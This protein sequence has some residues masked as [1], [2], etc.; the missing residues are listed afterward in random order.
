M[1]GGI[2]DSR[3]RDQIEGTVSRALARGSAFGSRLYNNAWSTVHAFLFSRHGSV[4]RVAGPHDETTLPARGVSGGGRHSLVVMVGESITSHE[5]PPSGSIEIGRAADAPL[6]IDAPSMS[7]RHLRLWIGTTVELEDLGGSNGT[8][9]RGVRLPAGKRV[10]ISCDEVF[11]AGD[12]GLVVQERGRSFTAGARA[13]SEKP[14]GAVTPSERDVVLLD[15]AMVR[16][17]A[18]AERVARGRIPVLIV[19]ETGSGKEVLAELVHRRSQRA[20]GP[21]VRINCAA[22]AETLVES[23]VFGHEK[24]AF[25]GADRARRGLLETADGGTVMFDEVGEMP[26]A[27]QAKLLRVLEEG[28]ILPVGS[29]TPRKI[30]IRVIAA[31]NRDL[32]HEVASGRFRSDLY[33]RLAGVVLEVPPLRE[34]PSEVEALARA[35]FMRAAIAA[36][37][38]TLRLGDAAI[39]ALRRH[40]WPGNVR[41][42]RSA[43]DRAALVTPG[44]VVEVEDIDLRMVGVGAGTTQ[45]AAVVAAPAA[46]A[47]ERQRIL[48]ALTECA[49]N[50]SRAAEVLGM[51]RRTLV[52]RL[53]EYGIPRPRKP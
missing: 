53:A 23:E 41:E 3:R 15:P 36:G 35:F 32:E 26:R 5:L 12:V 2:V 16:L 52:K 8:T 50:Q 29:T 4:D 33:F 45:S 38:D 24:G 22:I 21:L 44:D 47:D 46:P 1:P 6:R 40:P 48:D 34:R 9:L 10:A 19:G 30:D 25:T 18:L 51:P 42:L 43:M 20:A 31:T 7:R 11:M 28:A 37:R 39:A 49:G 17:H 14:S 27:I 13:K